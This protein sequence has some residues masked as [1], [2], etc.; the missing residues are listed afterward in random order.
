M[1]TPSTEPIA[2]WLTS[3]RRDVRFVWT[4]EAFDDNPNV[5]S[6]VRLPGTDGNVFATNSFHLG[7]MARTVCPLDAYDARAW[8]SGR[9]NDQSNTSV[10]VHFTFRFADLYPLLKLPAQPSV[11]ASV[12]LAGFFGALVKAALNVQVNKESVETVVE[13]RQVHFDYRSIL[14]TISEMHLDQVSIPDLMQVVNRLSYPALRDVDV[15]VPYQ[16]AV[17]PK[18]PRLQRFLIHEAVLNGQPT[19]QTICL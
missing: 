18:L 14:Q 8:S 17:H 10:G 6:D 12:Q 19:L 9:W 13:Q 7:Q 1:N 2:D 3:L 16:V 11:A 5:Q 15:S 4:D